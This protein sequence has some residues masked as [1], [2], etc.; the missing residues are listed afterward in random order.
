MLQ[1]L[2]MVKQ[3]ICLIILANASSLNQT[4]VHSGLAKQ[5]N[6]EIQQISTKETMKENKYLPPPHPQEKKK[7]KK[8]QQQKTKYKQNENTT[9]RDF[10]LFFWVW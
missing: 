1:T 6:P 8:Q 2:I 9:L 5:K 3:H 7:K 4:T 10:F